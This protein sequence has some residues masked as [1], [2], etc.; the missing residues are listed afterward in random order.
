M[1]VLYLECKMGA[2]GDMLMAALSELTDQKAFLEKMKSLGLEGLEIQAEPSVKCGIHGTHMKV[3]VSGEEET[4]EDVLAHEHHHGHDHEH[5]HDHEHGHDHH[6]HHH[7][8]HRHMSDIE[9]IIN[10]LHASE[11]VRSDALAV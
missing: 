4:S 2:A 6:Y 1:K 5:H 9:T 8:V 10:G 3:T 11:Q 7:H